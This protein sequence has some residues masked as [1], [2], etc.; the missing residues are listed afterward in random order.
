[1]KDSKIIKKPKLSKKVLITEIEQLDV[2]KQFNLISLARTNLA[3][4]IAIRDLLL[5]A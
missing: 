4:I 3:N 1:M 5:R 2:D